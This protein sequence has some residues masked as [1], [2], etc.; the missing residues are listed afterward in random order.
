LKRRGNSFS[1]YA[2]IIALLVHLVV[3]LT[4]AFIE[5]I[6]PT[7]PTPPKEEKPTESRFKVSLKEQPKAPKEALVKN[8][9]PKPTKARPMPKGEQLKKQIPQSKPIIEKTQSTPALQPQP[10]K[11]ET[12][13]APTEPKKA[14]ERH[15][16]K[17]VAT[18]DHTPKPKKEK[19]LY[20]ILSQADAPSKSSSTS[21]AKVS[22]NIKKLYGDKFGEL[23]EGEQ[24]YILDNQ[25]VMRRITQATLDRYGRSR[26]PD[27]LRTDETNMIEF[28]LHPDGSISDLRFLKNSQFSILDDT[29]KETIEIAYAKY[30]RPAQKTYIRYRVWYNLN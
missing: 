9:I 11:Q 22:D 25:E 16:A 6:T 24:K 17:E 29:T 14:F 8:T 27:N 28:Y 15:V 30:P 10:P 12:I 13:P 5:R 18:I 19:G 23:S 26:I 2:L 4:L 21:S 3:L 1:F 7:P 20:D